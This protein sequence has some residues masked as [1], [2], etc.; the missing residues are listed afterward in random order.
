MW[1]NGIGPSEID[2]GPNDGWTTSLANSKSFDQLRQQYKQMGCPNTG[3]P[4]PGGSHTLPW[5]EGYVEHPFGDQALKQV[6]GFS[7]YGSTTGNTTTF[8]ITNTASNSSF[9]GLTTVAPAY[10][11]ALEE[12]AVLQPSLDPLQLFDADPNGWD[13]PNGPTGPRHNIDQKFTWT[14][15]NVCGGG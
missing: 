11:S 15:Q 9:F 8:T 5:L 4:I 12:V 6:G 14:E 2:Y 1:Y 13:N 10:N 3:K 7:A